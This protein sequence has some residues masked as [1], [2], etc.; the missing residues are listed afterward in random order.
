MVRGRGEQHQVAARDEFIR[1]PL[2]ITD[3]R[4]GP[5]CIDDI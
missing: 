1:Q 2:M 5:G 4:V 3:D